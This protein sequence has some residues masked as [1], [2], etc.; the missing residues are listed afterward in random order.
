M[1]VK[2]KLQSEENLG[3]TA[4]PAGRKRSDISSV[5]SSLKAPTAPR[6][7]GALGL[8]PGDVNIEQFQEYRE[9]ARK[10]SYHSNRKESYEQF[11]A[12]Q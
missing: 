6:T 4:N 11:L 8:E 2:E 5:S 7:V 1:S 3:P 9:H 10:Q 12:D